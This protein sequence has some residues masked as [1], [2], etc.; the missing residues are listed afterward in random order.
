[1]QRGYDGDW[2]GNTF[3]IAVFLGNGLVAILAGLLGHGLVETLSL[4]PVAPFDAAAGGRRAQC[5][6]PDPR[7][8]CG[9]NAVHTLPADARLAEICTPFSSTVVLLI[10]GAVVISSWSENFGDVTDRSSLPEQLRKASSAIAADP[11]IALLGAMQ[12][13]FEGSMYTF[14]FLVS[15]ACSSSTR[16]RCHTRRP[17]LHSEQVEDVVRLQAG[18]LTLLHRTVPTVDAGAQPQRRAPA[19]RHDLQLLHGVQHGRLRPGRPHPRQ[20]RTA[21]G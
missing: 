8:S 9:I 11:K 19:A 14:V 17:P 2:L 10:G 3:S 21:C 7:I 6:E 20:A 13:L 4:G 12:S 16:T 1:M 5:H 18:R 15:V